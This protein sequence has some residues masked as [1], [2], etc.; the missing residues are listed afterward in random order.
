MALVL[1][2]SRHRIDRCG[3]RHGGESQRFRSG[4]DPECSRFRY[5]RVQSVTHGQEAEL[6][7]RL[8]QKNQTAIRRLIAAVKISCEFLAPDRWRSIRSKNFQ[9]RAKLMQ[10][11]LPVSTAWP[12][13]VSLPGAVSTVNP[14]LLSPSTLAASSRPPAGSGP[15]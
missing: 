10:D 13:G 12:V 2:S 11:G 9:A 15:K 6:A 14:T 3:F 4:H 8:S 7:L 5:A 1:R